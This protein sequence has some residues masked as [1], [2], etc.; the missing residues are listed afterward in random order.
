MIILYLFSKE[1]TELLRVWSIFSKDL[2]ENRAIISSWLLSC[3]SFE[4]LMHGNEPKFDKPRFQ[5][6]CQMEIL[7]QRSRALTTIQARIR[8][9]LVRTRLKLQGITFTIY[10][11]IG[12]NILKD[13]NND[14]VS[15]ENGPA[16][17][18][19]TADNTPDV[20]RTSAQS[21]DP[22]RH[23]ET[24]SPR[25]HTPGHADRSIEVFGSPSARSTASALKIYCNPNPYPTFYKPKSPPFKPSS[26][27]G[28]H[29]H[30]HTRYR[31]P[32]TTIHAG[33]GRLWSY[34]ASGHHSKWRTDEDGEEEEE[35]RYEEGGGRT[36]QSDRVETDRQEHRTSDRHRRSNSRSPEKPDPSGH[37][38]VNMIVARASPVS[39]P[40]ECDDSCEAASAHGPP[41]PR[42]AADTSRTSTSAVGEHRKREG[43][44][45]GSA[46]T[47]T[48]TTHIQNNNVESTP[49]IQTNESIAEKAKKE[50]L[51]VVAR[52]EES[53]DDGY[54][55]YED[56]CDVTD[57]LAEDSQNTTAT[58]ATK[59]DSKN[60]NIT[61]DQ[62]DL[63]LADGMGV[64][65]VKRVEE[66]DDTTQT[67]E[68]VMENRDCQTSPDIV[69]PH[70]EVSD[71]EV[72]YSGVP[73]PECTEASTQCAE[74]DYLQNP[75]VTSAIACA[76]SDAMEF[77]DAT[78]VVSRT[79]LMAV[80]KEELM[81]LTRAEYE[82]QLSVE[83]AIRALAMEI[84]HNATA[85]ALPI[86]AEDEV[87]A[88]MIAAEEAAAVR[89][90]AVAAA[91]KETAPIEESVINASDPV[92]NKELQKPTASDA[93]TQLARAAACIINSY[94]KYKCRSNFDLRYWVRVLPLLQALQD[95]N[96]PEVVC[97]ALD[98]S[99]HIPI[100]MLAVAAL[101][102]VIGLIGN[103]KARALDTVQHVPMPL[104][105]KVLNIYDADRSVSVTGCNLLILLIKACTDSS[106]SKFKNILVQSGSCE[107][108]ASILN[109]QCTSGT[110]ESILLQAVCAAM[111]L[112]SDHSV[113][114][115]SRL[116][117]S[118]L[119]R[120]IVTALE[121]YKHVRQ[122]TNSLLRLI[123]SLCRDC[124]RNRDLAGQEGVC[125]ALQNCLGVEDNDRE[126][127]AKICNA[128]MSLC[129]DG[130]KDNQRLL[131]S[132]EMCRAITEAM[133]DRTYDS[134]IEEILC[135]ITVCITLSSSYCKSIFVEAGLV[136]EVL[137]ILVTPRVSR[138][139]A[140]LGMWVIG[141][142]GMPES[143]TMKDCLDLLTSMKTYEKER[144]DD[145]IVNH[146]L[147]VVQKIYLSASGGSRGR[148]SSVLGS[149]GLVFPIKNIRA[150]ESKGKK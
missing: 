20:R 60:D 94:R 87:K 88:V 50:C 84:L 93:D 118:S 41:S 34:Y 116:G 6:L 126:S 8:G 42:S 9:M 32:R 104:V 105:C 1:L 145:K 75:K 79:L 144:S 33:R 53:R 55:D 142:L 83:A 64:G 15:S 67:L 96:D 47:T 121:A 48:T 143:S 58:V 99:C 25:D 114:T 128:V 139:I 125:G 76:V 11:N 89:A 14:S 82:H 107:I 110:T 19:P 26:V 54:D 61:H 100:P 117:S 123:L 49:V 72:Q 138:Q 28:E 71:A 3:S 146:V 5:E 63:H 27:R 4:D 127:F 77:S 18:T 141:C 135:T 2:T 130:H 45:E 13:G 39:G 31:R 149:I 124:R 147:L 101:R 24:A 52:R 120:T 129:A 80:I 16:H 131:A 7:F 51:E 40:M 37:V 57:F 62:K 133:E 68:A 46:A 95:T 132:K 150:A 69:P 70:T 113:A 106:N 111:M 22:R 103:S 98:L 92:E 90:S 30:T 23:V 74:I 29:T 137:R 136:D 56:D 97:D 109:K 12:R 21:T 119:F 140:L 108:L 102:K 59:N 66:R 43:S 10:K 44:A 73:P 81:K 38:N 148:Y 134:T 122:A 115:R 91:A 65:N 17:D 78:A 85:T 86:I 36:A 35:L 112:L